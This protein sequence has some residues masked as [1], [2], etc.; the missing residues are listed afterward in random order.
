MGGTCTGVCLSGV[1]EIKKTEAQPQV[2]FIFVCI[3]PPL[4]ASVSSTDQLPQIH[5]TQTKSK[6]LEPDEHKKQEFLS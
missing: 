1:L 2:K 5:L 3:S 6:L 4:C